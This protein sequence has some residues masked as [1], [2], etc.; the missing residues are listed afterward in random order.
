MSK[1]VDYSGVISEIKNRIKLE[2]LFRENGCQLQNAGIGRKKT[3]CPFHKE[4]TPS[5][6]IFN[7]SQSYHCFG[8]GESGDV[9][10]FFSKTHILSFKETVFELAKRAGIE[11][12]KESTE[13]MEVF[14]KRMRLVRDINSI[15]K[16]EYKKLPSNHPIKQSIRDRG[17][18]PD[19]DWYG[20][21]PEKTDPIMTKLLKTYSLEDFEAIKMLNRNNGLF[22]FNR[23]MFTINNY[24]GRPIAFSGRKIDE[25]D[26]KSGKYVNSQNS[27]I[28]DK[29]KALFNI[30]K[31]KKYI[32]DKKEVYVVEGQFDVISM[33]DNGY[34]NVVASSGTAFTKE[35]ATV[36]M[37][38]IDNGKII[39]MMDGDNAGKKAI[40]HIFDTFPELH[41]YAEAILLPD[42]QDPCD[43]LKENKTLP[44]SEPLLMMLYNEIEKE[45][46]SVNTAE[47]R[48]RIAENAYRDFVNKISNTLLRNEYSNKIRALTG[49]ENTTRFK[50]Q[51]KAKS[52]IKMPPEVSLVNLY[53]HNKGILEGI[54]KPEDF[55]DKYQRIISSDISIMNEKEKKAYE[56][57]LQHPVYIE[58][59][60][61]VISQYEYLRNFIKKKRR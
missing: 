43:Y 41:T 23:L 19:K 50:R 40:K 21:A 60:M 16:N 58:D 9:I 10:S 38:M 22:F 28:F 52:E 15:F 54:S 34:H 24:M 2:D 1:S 32:R 42:G 61:Q 30:D 57:I 39:F 56:W 26:T 5:M 12:D 17:L 27:E 3:N 33:Y 37:N 44:E 48:I 18:D 31:A 11:I 7:D 4:R 13:K 8:C 14:E 55:P 36:L 29:S 51:E 45:V 46:K 59:E 35:Q 49:M 53:I 6:V 47:D 25:T 20:L